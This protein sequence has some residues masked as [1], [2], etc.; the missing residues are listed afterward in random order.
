MAFGQ[1]LWSYAPPDSRMPVKAAKMADLHY[2]YINPDNPD[3]LVVCGDM[4]KWWNFG[5]NSGPGDTRSGGECDIIA[6]RNM[7]AGE[8]LLITA[9]SDADASRKLGPLWHALDKE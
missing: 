6:L 9:D 4:A 8:E 7:A 3:W 2:G 5:G 1:L